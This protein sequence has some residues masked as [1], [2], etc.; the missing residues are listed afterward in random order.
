MAVWSELL[1]SKVRERGR[2]DAEYYSPR[3]LA[4]EDRLGALSHVLLGD[5]GDVTCSAFYPAAT[6]L[7]ESGDIPFL[8]CTD[9]IDHPVITPDQ[10]FVRL[11]HE[12]VDEHT[13]IRCLNAGD[14]VI[15]KVGTPCYAGLLDAS[16]PRAA[17]SRTVLG[18]SNIIRAIVDPAYLVAFLRS[19]AG[20]EQL[21]RERELTIQY[22]LTLERTRDIRVYLPPMAIQRSIGGMLNQYAT[23]RRDAQRLYENAGNILLSTLGISLSHLH[24]A[25]YY[26]RPSRDV[27]PNLRLDAEYYQPKYERV[28]RAL[29]S[30][31]PISI[32]PLGNLLDYLANGH[33]PLRHDLSKGSVAFLTAEHVKDFR[34]DHGSEKRITIDHHNGEL[35]RTQIHDGDVLVTIKGRIGNAAVAQGVPGPTNIN[36]DVALLRV[37]DE[38]PSYYVV[39]YLNSLAGKLLIE[40][41]CTG[42]I[43]P[44][45]SLGNL[46]LVPIPIYP[47]DVM[48]HIANETKHAVEHAVSA[49]SN[50]AYVLEN[51]RASIDR[52]LSQETA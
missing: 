1:L 17:M 15:T 47:R 5:L 35:R 48:S 33:T 37:T 8:R 32:Q 19:E 43:N 16:M 30:T 10:S 24:D 29:S 23:I 28:L 4:L 2:I 51:A 44:F 34:V 49:D 9:V 40:Q 21:Q 45:L 18:L 14:I 11:P 52:L 6:D 41:I 20:F 36:Q 50:A 12:F 25:L 22:Q 7:Y 46:R 3:H 13:S 31:N 26:V 39:A 38:V 42:Q 27:P